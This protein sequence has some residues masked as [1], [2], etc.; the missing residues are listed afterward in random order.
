MIATL[1]SAS[2]ADVTENSRCSTIVCV[3]SLVAPDEAVDMKMVWEAPDD[4]WEEYIH[5]HMEAIRA[6]Y[7]PKNA[8]PKVS[9]VF[10]PMSLP[11]PLPLD[12]SSIFTQASAQGLLFHAAAGA[13]G[14]AAA[15]RGSISCRI[16]HA[17]CSN[18]LMFCRKS[19]QYRD[20]P[21]MCC[22]LDG[23]QKQQGLVE[24]AL[25][26]QKTVEGLADAAATNA[27]TGPIKVPLHHSP[28]EMTWQL[29]GSRDPQAVR[30]C[31]AATCQTL[32]LSSI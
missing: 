22:V 32:S 31:L 8:K 10:C 6:K 16:K 7:F 5:T 13:S 27:P 28:A 12:F 9:P 11:S 29:H 15:T 4:D 18:W 24:K 17:C 3:Q 26:G 23:P 30:L 25:P 20:K 14:A 1:T 19:R 21:L 2:H